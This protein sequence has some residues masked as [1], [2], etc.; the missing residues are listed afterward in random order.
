MNDAWADDPDR[1]TRR[2]SYDCEH[3]GPVSRC[4]ICR[5]AALRAAGAIIPEPYHPPVWPVTP[6][7]IYFDAIVEQAR[8]EARRAG[9]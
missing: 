7:P 2:E 4:A 5:R 1:T 3:G 9:G 6:K 8:E